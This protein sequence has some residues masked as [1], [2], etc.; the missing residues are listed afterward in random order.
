MTQ[1]PCDQLVAEF[2]AFAICS[3][4]EG[5]PDAA[6]RISRGLGLLGFLGYIGF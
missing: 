3:G 4:D 6:Y 2:E 1:S 5:N